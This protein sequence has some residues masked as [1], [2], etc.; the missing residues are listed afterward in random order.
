MAFAVYGS[1]LPF[2]LHRLPVDTAWEQFRASVLAGT[3]SRRL[4]RTDVLANVLLFVP[5]GFALAGSLLVDR[6]S[7]L[8]AVPAVVVALAVSIPLSVV[9]EF[10]QLFTSERVPS[11]SDILAQT[12]GC[13]LGIIAWM[14]AGRGL[15]T[16]LRDTLASAPESR[17]SRLLT[18]YAAA[19]L[20]VNLAPFDIT[21][22][23]G[24]LADRVRSGE[25]NVVPFAGF[26]AAEPRDL[27]DALAETLAAVPL[28]LLGVV[29][30]GNRA[31]RSRGAA[32]AVGGTLVV[33]V[34]LAQVF[35]GSHAADATDVVFG[36]F[37]T[38]IGVGLAR[39]M[40]SD[41]VPQPSSTA[42]GLAVWPGLALLAAWVIVLCAYHW[43]PYDFGLDGEL[44]R[45][46][47]GRMSLLPFASYGAGSPLNA[48]NDLLVKLS[49]SIPF[50]LAAA[51]AFQR[52]GLSPRAVAAL[53][54]VLAL[55]VFGSIEAGQLF[56]PSRVP[57]TTDVLTG[58]AGTLIG[59]TLARWLGGGD[60]SRASTRPRR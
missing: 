19:W 49:L 28:G 15:T 26:D 34:E 12:V 18:G 57:D 9:S 33:C 17:L 13:V 52:I 24:D 60:L 43:L 46:K 51:F 10:L 23:L 37:G 35:I 41:V 55:G 8:A 31:V 3:A 53:A 40:R 6:R 32:F 30:L 44:I 2:D 1:L 56:L 5:V 48:L 45:R 21:V 47:L 50:G 7:R 22:D 16:W 59:L 42:D 20:F 58:G 29:G 38:A 11:R 4:S 27:W 39:R 54:L 25:I 36:W 14:V